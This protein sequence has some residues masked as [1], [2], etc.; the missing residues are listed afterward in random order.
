MQRIVLLGKN[1]Q[2]G[3]EM[4]ARLGEIGELHAFDRH[5]LNLGNDDQIRSLI[6]DIKPGLI[7][8]TAA[9]T[10]VDKAEQ[11]PELARQINSR[12][13]Q[14]LAEE[15]RACKALLVH[16]S[17]DYVF[18]GQGEQPWTED[19]PTDPLNVYGQTK[20]DGELAITETG[21]AHLIFRTSWVYGIHGANFVKTMLRLAR[22]RSELSIVDDQIGA[23]T[24]AAVIAATSI[25]ILRQAQPPFVEYFKDLSG[26]YHLV[27]GGETSWYRFALQIFTEARTHGETLALQQVNPIPSSAYPVPA[28]RPLNSRLST[29]KI[30]RSFNVALPD[31]ESALVDCFPEI[32][33]T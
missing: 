32:M 28:L 30:R 11:E 23:P 25:A 27:C 9:Y 15:A 17:T 12:A 13:P 4:A 19:Q 24:S 16:Y 8:N 33:S 5:G 29:E 20:R 2:L 10:A 3:H 7:V 31:W 21:C 14:V 22:E 18:N 1:G 26:I 6:R